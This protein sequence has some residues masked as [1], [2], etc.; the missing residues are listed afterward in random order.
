LFLGFEERFL[1]SSSAFAGER[2]IHGC[3]TPQATLRYAARFQGRAAAGHFRELP[4]GLVLSSIGIGTYL[5][6]ADEATDGAYEDAIVAA[7]EGC[8]NVID[9]AIN[10]RL[11][12]SERSV[13]AALR[14]LI[15][16]GF[17]REEIL[18][19]TKAGFLTPDGEMPA[20]PNE[21]F[22]REFLERGIFRA[23]EIAAGCHCMT[24]AYLADQL[25][26]SR[27]N[28]GVGCVDVF[29]LHNPETQLTEVSV[30]AFRSR[31]H[32]AFAFL[33]S[34]VSSGQIGAYGM[35]TWNAFREE[36]KSPGY[37]SL[38]EMAEIAREAGGAGHH[39][40]FVQLPLNLAM[41]EALLRPN[42][43]VEGKTMAMVQAAR[44][45]GIALISS[46][47]LLQGQLTRNLPPYIHA[48]LEL[49]DDTAC[50][51][52]FVRSVP[53]VTTALVGMSQVP[54]VRANLSLIGV[55]PAPRDQFLKLFESHS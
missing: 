35:A 39:F 20:D 52:Q 42:Q 48:A 30:E 37:L 23:D 32:A 14:E 45:L 2:L 11:Q 44:A 5:G 19:C 26:R 43:I 28:L 15:S 47:S 1:M 8:F 40:R 6:E 41:P 51:L 25:D 49:Q 38:A 9:A 31:I 34:A 7:V 13:G 54:H 17:S 18:L 27:R 50:A 24:P 55:E 46:A 29:Y 33:E 4:G 22:A 16:K 12:R 53:G 3:A 36:P 10:Y 21:Y